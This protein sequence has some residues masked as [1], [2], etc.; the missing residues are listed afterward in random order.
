MHDQQDP[1]DQHD[2]QAQD[3]TTCPEHVHERQCTKCAE[4]AKQEA[5]RDRVVTIIKI[6]ITLITAGLG[7]AAGFGEPVSALFNH[8]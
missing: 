3:D 8:L 6:A 1:Q 7:W 2:E 4:R 5:R